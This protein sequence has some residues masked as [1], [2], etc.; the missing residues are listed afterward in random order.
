MAAVVSTTASIPF[1]AIKEMVMELIIFS[2]LYC[3]AEVTHVV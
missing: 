1:R 3:M 2:H